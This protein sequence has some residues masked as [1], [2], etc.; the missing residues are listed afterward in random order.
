MKMIQCHTYKENKKIWIAPNS[1][2]SFKEAE[3]GTDIFMK[4]GQWIAVNENFADVQ[5]MVFYLYETGNAK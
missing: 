5:R 1:I 2:E 4:S 3:Y